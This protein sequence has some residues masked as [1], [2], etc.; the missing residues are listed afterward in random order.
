M[1]VHMRMFTYVQV[2]SADTGQCV[3][4][5]FLFSVIKYYDKS[6]LLLEESIWFGAYNFRRSESVTV[7]AE[8]MEA[9]IVLEQ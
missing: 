8:S 1:W 2:V 7:M 5:T 6:Y 4:V 3:L 9:D